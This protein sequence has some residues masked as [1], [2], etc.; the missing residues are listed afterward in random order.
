M[1]TLVLQWK[2]NWEYLQVTG[3]FQRVFYYTLEGVQELAGSRLNHL[4]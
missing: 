1:A 4:K 3:D 2:D